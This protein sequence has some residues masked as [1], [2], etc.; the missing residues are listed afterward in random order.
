[1]DECCEVRPIPREQRRVL[2]VVLWI[3]AAMFLAESV[4]GVLA[5]ST[6]LFADSMD[7]LGDAVVYGFSLYVVGR[8]LVWQAR[9][10]LLKGLVMGAFGLGVLVQVA[11]KL[12]QGLTPSVELMGAVGVL[13]FAANLCCLALL[14]RRRGDDINM[15][16]AF[17]CSRNDVIGN[18]AVLIAAV[19][20]AVTGSGWPDIVIGLLVAVVFGRSA[21]QVVRE[22]AR[23]AVATG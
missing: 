6:A 22:A 17:V 11:V 8:G 15:R 9:A 5:H 10:A 18:T 4:A 14:W 13:A 20:V 2:H 3:N 1:M 12:A 19:A 7:M 16:S 21:V 23:A